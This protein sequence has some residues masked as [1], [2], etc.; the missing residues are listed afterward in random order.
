LAVVCGSVLIGSGMVYFVSY[1]QKRKNIESEE[2]I[3]FRNETQLIIEELKEELLS[4]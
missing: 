1:K 4:K 2:K 3:K